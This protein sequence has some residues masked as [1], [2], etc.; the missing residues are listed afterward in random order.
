MKWATLKE[1]I[2]FPDANQGA[3]RH[4]FA[5]ISDYVTDL[6]YLREA[7]YAL[8]QTAKKRWCWEMQAPSWGPSKC[9]VMHQI[10]ET[11]NQKWADLHLEHRINL[12]W[13]SLQCMHERSSRLGNN[14]RS[15]KRCKKAP[16]SRQSFWRR[17][18]SIIWPYYYAELFFSLPEKA[19]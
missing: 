5:H 4:C 14:T 8:Y 3:A 11:E 17:K 9:S 1:I 10:R 7:I 19:R 12:G 15:L 13:G 18:S 2:S 16:A 6:S